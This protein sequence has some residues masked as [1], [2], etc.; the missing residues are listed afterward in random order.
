MTSNSIL[1][2]STFRTMPKCLGVAA[3]ALGLLASSAVHA[4]T[5]TAVSSGGFAEA[6]K[7]LSA[8]YNAGNTG[9]KV[10][11][12]FGPSM[13]KTANAI[14]ARLA[15]GETVDVVIM[16][17]GALDKLMESGQ[18]EPGS[19]VVLANSRIAC[20]VPQGKPK[21]DLRTVA[22]VRQAF[23]D[24]PSIAWSDSASG[25]YIQHEMLARLGIEAEVKK[26]GRQIPAT[27]VGEILAR[28]EAAFGC[29][30]HSELQ[31]VHGI[32]IVGELPDELQ[33]V[34]PYAAAVVKHSKHPAAS[35]A[36]I[37][38]LAA[39]ANAATIAETGLVPVAK[40]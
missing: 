11:T 24:A 26:K 28:G 25:E 15:R 12:S 18:L 4:Q 30:Q 34:T 21:P 35:K 17:G 9:T 1:A 5:I 8:R 27:P 13:G 40:K 33:R 16:V 36:F 19:K 31:P 22:S 23:L 38:F 20:A 7:T 3:I 32:D 29:Q 2:F 10:E 39:P 6:F 14:P 37:N